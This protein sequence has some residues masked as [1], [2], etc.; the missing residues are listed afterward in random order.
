MN[1]R[2]MVGHHYLIV[3]ETPEGPFQRLVIAFD[4]EDAIEQVVAYLDSEGIA[5]G[6]IVTR[7]F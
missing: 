6:E 3:T 4:E 1:P 5:Y 2:D 7:H